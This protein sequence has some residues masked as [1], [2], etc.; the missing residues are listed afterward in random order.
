MMIAARNSFT[1]NTS[2]YFQSC[3]LTYKYNRY[4]TD[5]MSN[6]IFHFNISLFSHIK[7]KSTLQ[8][9]NQS[10]ITSM[11]CGCGIAIRWPRMKG[12]GK[13]NRES[14]KALCPSE[15]LPQYFTT[16]NKMEE[17]LFNPTQFMDEFRNRRSRAP[18][19][20]ISKMKKASHCKTVG[21]ATE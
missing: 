11:L 18:S 13:P 4:Q 6:Y 5:A 3:L 20:E 12:H 8:V 21:K 17:Y 15:E 1:I 9:L 2:F 7:L 10:T 16:E 19:P 14:D